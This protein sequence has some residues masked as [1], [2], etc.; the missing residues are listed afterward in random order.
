MII[1]SSSIPC[2][3]LQPP[4][5]LW[6][7]VKDRKGQSSTIILKSSVKDQ[8]TLGFQ[9]SQEKLG[10]ISHM[11]MPKTS[12]SSR[13]QKFRK[14][15]LIIFPLDGQIQG[16]FGVSTTGSENEKYST[17]HTSKFLWYLS[18]RP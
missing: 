14:G 11:Y 17:L 12:I 13:I 3:K 16:E 18:R 1:P 2:N 15:P 9:T 4:I 5:D 10:T 6:E 7:Q 8:I